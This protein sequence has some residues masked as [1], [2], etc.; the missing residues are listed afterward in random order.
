[1]GCL[2]PLVGIAEGSREVIGSMVEGIVE[3][4]VMGIAVNIA[5]DIAGTLENL[6]GW[7]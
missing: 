5:V 4:I 2:D 3:G 1:M 7:W 6:V